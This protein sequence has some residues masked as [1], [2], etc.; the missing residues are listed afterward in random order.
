MPSG[1]GTYGSKVGRPSKKNKNAYMHGGKPHKKKHM[2]GGMMKMGYEDGG[3]FKVQPGPSVDGIDVATNVAKHV[4]KIVADACKTCC[5]R[6]CKKLSLRNRGRCN[7]F[8][9]HFVVH[10][11]WSR[12]KF[13]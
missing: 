13:D 10:F 1:P 3:Q 6:C 5:K 11:Y 2:G 8:W 4:A 12:A 9:P 7:I